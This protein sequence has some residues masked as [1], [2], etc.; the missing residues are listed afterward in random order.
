MKWELWLCLVF[1]L[2]APIKAQPENCH[3]VLNRAPPISPKLTLVN[4]TDNGKLYTTAVDGVEVR[5]LHVFGSPYE[6]GYAQGVLLRSTVQDLYPKFFDFLD[7]EIDQYIDFLPEDIRRL[8]E[9][10]GVRLA[11]EATELATRAFTPQ[12]FYDELQGLSDGSGVPSADV[13][14]LHMFP[15]L[16]KAACSMYGAWG[17]AINQ[18][19]GT[20]FQLRALDWGVNSPLTDVPQVTVYHP[21][22]GHPFLILT[23]SGFIGALTGYSGW[24]GLCEKVW[25]HYNGTSSRIGYP[26]HF[27]TRDI[28]Q[29]DVDISSAINRIEQTERT[30]SIFLGLGDNSTNQFRVVEYAHEYAKV[31]DPLNYPKQDHPY[32]PDVVYVDKHTQPSSDPCMPSLLSQYYGN[33]NISNAIAVVSLFQTGD[34]HAAFYDHGASKVYIS[35]AQYNASQ[36][37]SSI[38]AYDRQWM[39]LDFVSLANEMSP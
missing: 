35:V 12:Y 25:L 33:L 8:I 1:C 16:I 30:C 22:N 20:L 14:N 3:G 38:P 28:L 37:D 21:D 32:F 10:E 5:V 13:I 23:F 34:L 19:Q 31:F 27:L 24:M 4:T 39:A 7:S 26:W 2:S 9:T 11:L 36:P 18:T 29:F 6:M 17:T 15:E